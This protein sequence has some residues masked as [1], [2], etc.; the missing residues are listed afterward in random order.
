MAMAGPLIVIEGADGAGKST[1]LARLCRRLEQQGVAFRRQVF[2]RYQE[3]SAALLKMYL[4]GEF[5]SDPDAVNPYAASTFFA[6][7]RYASYKCDWQGYHSGGGL[8]ICD[9][10]TTSNA[11]HQAAKLPPEKAEPFLDWLFDFEYEKLGLPQPTLVFFLDLPAPLALQLLQK[12]QGDGGDIHEKD[13]E[14]LARCRQRAL[15]V[16]MR[17]GWHRIDCAPGGHLRTVEQ[18]HEEIWQTVQNALANK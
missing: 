4:G 1:Q 13:E 10:Y 17:Y 7:D 15:A 14:Y 9:R 12:R 18:I 3:P 8:V 16:C 5:G 6:V 11:V 2:P